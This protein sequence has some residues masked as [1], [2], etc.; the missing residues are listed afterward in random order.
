MKILNEE[1]KLNHNIFISEIKKINNPLRVIILQSLYFGK[2]YI[3]YVKNKNITSEDIGKFIAEN[4][5]KYI[6]NLSTAKMKDKID[7]K[8]LIDIIKSIKNNL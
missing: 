8:I 6:L 4:I 2:D 1:N 3:N 7:E 5:Q